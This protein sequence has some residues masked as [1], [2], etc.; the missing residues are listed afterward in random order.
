MYAILAGCSIHSVTAMDCLLPK[1]PK[2]QESNSVTPYV[3]AGAAFAVARYAPEIA[4]STLAYAAP[5]NP[6]AQA[7]V[8]AAIKYGG[9]GLGAHLI[10]KNACGINYSDFANADSLK[11]MAHNSAKFAPLMV[12]HPEVAQ[13]TSEYGSQLA[14]CMSHGAA[15]TLNCP[16]MKPALIATGALTAACLVNPRLAP[17]TLCHPEV[18]QLAA[19]CCRNF[20]SPYLSDSQLKIFDTYAA[21]AIMT[22]GAAGTFYLLQKSGL[23][24]RLLKTAK[25]IYKDIRPYSFLAPLAVTYNADSIKNFIMAHALSSDARS[26]IQSDIGSGI[27]VGLYCGGLGLA[28][29]L[30][31][32]H[33]LDVPT[34]GYVKNK[35]NKLVS[36]CYG[37][38]TR[39]ANL[40]TKAVILAQES[41][42]AKN[43]QLEQDK[44]L[45]DFAQKAEEGLNA[46]TLL[47]AQTEGY[48]KRAVELLGDLQRMNSNLQNEA[49]NIATLTQEVS[50]MLND[51]AKAQ[52]A[53]FEKLKATITDQNKDLFALIDEHSKQVAAQIAEIKCLCTAEIDKLN[54]LEP[55]L[56]GLVKLIQKGNQLCAADQEALAQIARNT[57]ETSKILDN[58]LQ[59]IALMQEALSDTPGRP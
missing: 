19:D 59:R 3:R 55:K 57:Q 22:A 51:I 54:Q 18:A 49:R 5:Q 53:Q 52:K 35:L 38:K 2:R 24:A 42:R 39:L 56:E 25:K 10:L 17:A 46:Q 30:F 34:Q 32:T 28:S 21:P 45:R 16:H 20:A 8:P 1:E 26:N 27:K 4:S 33:T 7:L 44:Q 9:Y 14:T 47:L 36:M 40:Q 43:A 6:L 12:C 37:I 58:A 29:Y 11:R 41:E 48:Q 23:K 31:I 50:A 13:A 15:A